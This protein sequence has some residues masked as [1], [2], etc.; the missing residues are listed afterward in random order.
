MLSQAKLANCGDYQV[1][2]G[3]YENKPLAY[4]I[5]AVLGI[6]NDPPAH[7][8][9]LEFSGEKHYDVMTNGLSLFYTR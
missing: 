9:N 5:V 6:N 2:R 8:I 7:T 1:L 3:Q 4:Y